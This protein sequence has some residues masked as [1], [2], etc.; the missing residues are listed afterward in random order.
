M[1]SS[2]LGYTAGD[3]YPMF[4]TESATQTSTNGFISINIEFINGMTQNDL[5]S[6]SSFNYT[7]SPRR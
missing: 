3:A 1:C 2:D 5:L 6:T 4:S 7:I